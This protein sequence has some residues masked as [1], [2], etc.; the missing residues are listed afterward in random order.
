MRVKKLKDWLGLDLVVFVLE[1]A[2]SASAPPRSGSHGVLMQR[3]LLLARRLG[4]LGWTSDGA[5]GV[6]DIDAVG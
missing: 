5:L 2:T 4:W 1:K 6:G 3:R